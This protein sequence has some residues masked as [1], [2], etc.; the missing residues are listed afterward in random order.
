MAT[1][2]FGG[3]NIVVIGS[4]RGIGF[5]L[6]RQLS[7]QGS[8]SI[9]AIDRYESED[10]SKLVDSVD[11][12]KFALADVRDNEAL[13]V[14]FSSAESTDKKNA[15]GHIDLVDCLLCV[16]GVLGS[17]SPLLNRPSSEPN[18]SE[19]I[20]NVF[21]I[22]VLGTFNGIYAF[23]SKMPSGGKIMLMSSTMASL[24]TATHSLNP[25]YSVAKAGVNMLGRKLAVELKDRDINVILMS[26]G[27]VRTEM[28][29]GQGDIS[30][31]QSVEGILRELTRSGTSGTFLRYDGQGWPW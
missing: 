4:A 9:L 18:P 27:V 19:D 31:Q 25:A 3:K 29:D 13:K 21:A 26:P 12:V 24:E 1:S 16:S 11:N 23:Q 15:A 10:I 5:E 20:L 6:V 17:P 14:R 22:N 8:Q 7:E 30:T 2:F 28:N